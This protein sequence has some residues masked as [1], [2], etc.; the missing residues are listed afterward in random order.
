MTT[1][2]LT[3]S[4][5]YLVWASLAAGLLAVILACI[6]GLGNRFG[7]FHFRTALDL[8]RWGATVGAA[9]AAAALVCLVL[10][11]AWKA[12]APLLKRAI[13]AGIL[14]LAIFVPA[15]L[16][17]SQAQALPRIHDISTDVVNPPVFQA[18]LPLRADAPNSAEYGGPEIAQQQLAAYPDIEAKQLKIGMEDAYMRALTAARA[19]GWEIIDMDPG[20]GRIEAVDTTLFFGFK[21]DVVVRIRPVENGTSQ[22][23]IR[24]V[25]RVGLSD[26]GANAARIRKFL[27][28]L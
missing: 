6:G 18:I 20:Q 8:F 19:M 25:S 14:G 5:S 12:P 3:R 23:D 24:S 17:K 22:V 21:D 27:K 9:A 15:T 11:L 13:S 16:F 26:V 4:L 28:R 7:Y 10:A 2:K 1:N